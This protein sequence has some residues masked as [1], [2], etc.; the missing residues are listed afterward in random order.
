MYTVKKKVSLVMRNLFIS[1]FG[2]GGNRRGTRD[3]VREIELA[4]KQLGIKAAKVGRH[5]EIADE[6]LTRGARNIIHICDSNMNGSSE[7]EAI[8]RRYA[9]SETKEVSEIKDAKA[10]RRKGDKFVSEKDAI[11]RHSER[12]AKESSLLQ[13]KAAAK[14]ENN[15]SETDHASKPLGIFASKSVSR[16]INVGGVGTP[17][18]V[19]KKLAAKTLHKCMKY[20]PMLLQRATCVA[21]LPSRLAAK[22]V[23]FTLAEVLITLGII[24]VVAALTIPNVIKQYQDRVTVTKLQKAYSVLNQAFRQSEN[25][26]GSSEF[27]QE[28]DEIGTKAY[29]EKYWKPYFVEPQLCK[30]YKECGYTSVAPYSYKDGSHSAL[31]ISSSRV[32]FKTADDVFYFFTDSTTGSSGNV[33]PLKNVYIDINGAKAPNKFGEDVFVF[34]R[35][36]GKGIMPDSYA[37]Q[38]I[39]AG[40]KI[41]H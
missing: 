13:Y 37:A 33:V 24:G 21:P 32:F 8:S 7:R 12:L 34:N 25:D 20:K 39:A 14:N 22:K 30:T 1:A 17:P 4:A 9:D 10:L 2:G 11:G 15:S 5:C 27:W 19:A 3:I 41:K 36:A 38:I 23:A 31:G 6:W 40:W 35:V 18:Y 16:K 29:F 26:N 28:T